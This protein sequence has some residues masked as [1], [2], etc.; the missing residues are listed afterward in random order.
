MDHLR[1]ESGRDLPARKGMPNT[2]SFFYDDRYTNDS[3]LNVYMTSSE[4]YP[5]DVDCTDNESSPY[6]DLRF[7]DRSL[8][9][10]ESTKNPYNP[11]GQTSEYEKWSSLDA[12]HQSVQSADSHVSIPSPRDQQPELNNDRDLLPVQ[13]ISTFPSQPACTQTLLRPIDIVPKKWTH[14]RLRRILAPNPPQDHPVQSDDNPKPSQKTQLRVSQPKRDEGIVIPIASTVYEDR[15]E[16][17][18]DSFKENHPSTSNTISFSCTVGFENNEVLNN[19]FAVSSDANNVKDIDPSFYK[20]GYTTDNA[21]Q[22]GTCAENPFDPADL[23]GRFV[24][25]VSAQAPSPTSISCPTKAYVSQFENN[26]SFPQPNNIVQQARQVQ[27]LPTL[28]T[29]PMEPN[30]DVPSSRFDSNYYQS[31]S[32]VFVHDP[33][34]LTNFIE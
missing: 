5:G 6:R 29:D 10:G 28:S 20:N 32:R 3:V 1:N 26:E 25:L 13:D 11:T 4:K 17:K 24:T 2:I 19:G 8:L 31:D 21:S 22:S 14:S 30:P 12:P 16:S 15:G 7:T 27:P 33:K 18:I 23:S 34:I 9:S